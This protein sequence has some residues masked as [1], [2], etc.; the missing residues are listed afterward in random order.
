MIIIYT[1]LQSIDYSA[2]SNAVHS[3]NDTQTILLYNIYIQLVPSE[4]VIY[5]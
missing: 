5:C 2:Q 1:Q 3:V 4:K